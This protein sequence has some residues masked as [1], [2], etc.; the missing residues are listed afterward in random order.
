LSFYYY[1]IQDY[2]KAYEYESRTRLQTEASG[3]TSRKKSLDEFVEGYI[4]DWQFQK[5]LLTQESKK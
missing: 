1:F 5:L 3:R 2:N 4:G